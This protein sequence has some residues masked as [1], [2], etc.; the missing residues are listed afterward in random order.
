VDNGTIEIN[1]DVLVIGS[2]ISGMSFALKVA[3]TDARVIILL[4]LRNI[5]SSG[6]NSSCIFKER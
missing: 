3:K 6:G 1:C 2:G 5:F 4:R